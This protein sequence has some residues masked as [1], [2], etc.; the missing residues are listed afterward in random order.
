M[1][2]NRL[3]FLSCS[4]S[5]VQLSY[6][7]FWDFSPPIKLVDNVNSNAE[8]TNPWIETIG[9]KST[10]YFVRTFDV[11][12]AG[13]KNDQ[14][15][16]CSE[17]VNNTWAKAENVE[18]LNNEN[19]NGIGRISSGSAYVLHSD[20]K[21]SLPAIKISK[22]RNE[23]SASHEKWNL[24]T[25][26][27]FILDS[28]GLK[29]KEVGFTISKDEKWM[30]LSLNL[31]DSYGMEDLYLF[32]LETS[33]LFHLPSEINSAG[34]EI[35]P[36]L[37]DGADTLFFASNGLGGFGDCDLFY[38]V[39]GKSFF[40][41]SKPINFG[42]KINSSGFDAYLVKSGN[43]IYW[44]SNRNSDNSDIYTSTILFPPKLEIE[45]VGKN[46][47]TFQGSDGEVDLIVKSG[48]A[49]FNYRWSNGQKSEDIIKL[50]KGT[51]EVSVTDSIGQIAVS[52]ITLTEPKPETKKVIRLPTVYYEFKTGKLI[53][54]DRINSFDSLDVIAK[55]LNEYPGMSLELISHTD[56]RGNEKAN[57][58][59]SQI[60]A[61]AVFT[62]LVREKGIDGRRLIP[63]G[64][65]ELSPSVI[66]DRVTGKSITLT[67][68]YIN[69]FKDSNPMEFERLHQLNRRTEGRVTGMNFDPKKS[70]PVNPKFFI[71]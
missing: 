46:V 5:F 54:N 15:I 27:S 32:N 50:K 29:N 24:P 20:K 36:F 30:F 45:L 59:L 11:M 44:S 35:S 56:S 34:Y 19:H 58:T 51:Y 40:E 53:N 49:P 16:W 7:Q 71:D 61:R 4:I 10:L 3:F 68:A 42:N 13:G 60:R 41:W 43:T 64:K 47:S 62:Y 57:I 9:G 18:N 33:K 66:I 67:E 2:F 31:K 23:N 22:I 14:D 37:S 63:V 6:A 38:S 1:R 8:E 25:K 70:A 26:T 12:N 28:L 39:R 52:Q 48:V 21:Q 69:Q 17:F 65:G 55:L